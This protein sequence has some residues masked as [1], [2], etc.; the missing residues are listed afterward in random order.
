MQKSLIFPMYLFI[1]IIYYGLSHGI[2]LFKIN[3][4][5]FDENEE[6]LF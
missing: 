3:E 2:Y 6:P 5:L 4:K 1:Q